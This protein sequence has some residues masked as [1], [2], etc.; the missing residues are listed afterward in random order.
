MK[1]LFF[2]VF[3]LVCTSHA[4]SQITLEQAYPATA[5]G[6]RAFSL[7]NLGKAGFKYFDVNY[8]TRELKLYNLNHSV[9]LSHTISSPATSIGI[10]YVASDL[11]D[12]DSSNIEL[13][14]NNVVIVGNTNYRYFEIVRT[15]G[16]VLFHRDSSLVVNSA[17][18]VSSNFVVNTPAG[19]KMLLSTTTATPSYEVYSLCGTIPLSVKKIDTFDDNALQLSPNPSSHQTRVEYTLPQGTTEGEVIITD[20]TGKT[21]QVFKVDVN[22]NHIL[23]SNADLPSGTYYYQLHTKE[24]GTINTKKALVIK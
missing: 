10:A 1:K 22:F 6:N 18:N 12:C 5:A 23:L 24:A 7:I 16:T 11:F 4:K 3:A 21:I 17:V 8:Q 9:F 15:N 2:F 20:V 13:A 14:I 19:V